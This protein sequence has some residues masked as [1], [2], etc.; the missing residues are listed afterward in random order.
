MRTSHGSR[1]RA[2]TPI[3]QPTPSPSRQSLRGADA[4]GT[5]GLQVVLHPSTTLLR[6]RF[7]V[8]SAWQANQPGADTAIRCWKAE[9]AIVA[10]P[11]HEVT[12]TR[13]PDGGFAFLSALSTGSTLATAIEAALRDNAAFDLATNLAFLAGSGTVVA[14]AR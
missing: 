10:R 11:H 1:L 12:V 5:A 6:S 7:P 14:L 13:L 4:G 8:V 3:T 9:D 2:A